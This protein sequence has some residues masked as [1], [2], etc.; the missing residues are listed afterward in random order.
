MNRT[1][2]IDGEGEKEKKR[3]GGKRRRETKNRKT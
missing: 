3:R 1:W 2:K